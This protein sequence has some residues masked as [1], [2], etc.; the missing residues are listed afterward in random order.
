[1]PEEMIAS[2]IRRTSAADEVFKTLHQ[3]IISGRLKAGDRMPSQ[4][5]LARQFAVSRNTLREAIFKLS[6]L[7]LVRAK[8]GVGTVVQPSGP[9][10]Y[11]TSIYDH[12]LLDPIT[13]RELIEARI[14]VER[15]TVRLAVARAE[16]ADVNNLTA[17]LK[18]QKAAIDNQ[19]ADE[20]SRQDVTFHLD[21]ARVS[22]NSVLLRFLQ[23][24]WDLMHKFIG[25]VSR[26]PGATEEALRFHT[27]IV[28]ALA[29]GDA[30]AAER[31]MI[32]HLWDVVERIETHM[33]VDLDAASLF[34][35]D[36]E[37]KR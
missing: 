30:A 28:D 36:E 18:E 17:L 7:G 32:Q 23:A 15:T 24:I 27:S 3:W 11:V 19:A 26:L 12:L 9:A 22:R 14:C 8:Q 35:L 33:D 13:V 6:A 5:D 4:D 2:S 20:F 29:A 10:H 21:L 31:L 1:M 25:E 34:G 37:A 16:P